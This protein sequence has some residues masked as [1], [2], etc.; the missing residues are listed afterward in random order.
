MHADKCR[1]KTYYKIGSNLNF[2][3]LNFGPIIKL[4]VKLEKKILIK[5]YKVYMSTKYIFGVIIIYFADSCPY[6]LEK[7]EKYFE[8]FWEGH[9]PLSSI[10]ILFIDNPLFIVRN[11]L[12]ELSRKLYHF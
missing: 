12:I 9:G 1:N 6:V 3:F 4:R 11:V 7:L 5:D 10:A 2:F 8:K